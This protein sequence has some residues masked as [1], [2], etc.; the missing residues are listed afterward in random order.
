MT[1][2]KFMQIF[3][4]F[5]QL[6]HFETEET[7]SAFDADSEEVVRFN[8]NNI[9]STN[10]NSVGINY[11]VAFA[12]QKYGYSGMSSYQSCEECTIKDVISTSN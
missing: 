8:L 6:S 1:S 12:I 9:F 3:I 11:T 5:R 4:M 2:D 10:V 7:E